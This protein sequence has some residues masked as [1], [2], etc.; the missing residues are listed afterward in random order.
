MESV[1]YCFS[2]W[3][4]CR[5]WAFLLVLLLL[6]LTYNVFHAHSHSVFHTKEF[7]NKRCVESGLERKLIRGFWYRTESTHERTIFG[8]RTVINIFIYLYFQETYPSSPPV[9]FADAEEP[10]VTNAIQLLSNTTG[11]DNHVINQVSVS[12]FH[13]TVNHRFHFF[14]NIFFALSLKRV[15]VIWFHLTAHVLCDDDRV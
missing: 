3:H 1:G 7:I 6:S 5:C 14:S 15:I 12:L 4:C 9:W 8:I 11:I 10:I 2:N 13:F